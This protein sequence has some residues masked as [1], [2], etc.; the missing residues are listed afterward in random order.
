MASEHRAVALAA[1]RGAASGGPRR[2]AATL[3]HLKGLALDAKKGSTSNDRF[4]TE[5]GATC[6]S[7]MG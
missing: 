4:L 1:L 2:G 5:N 7:V 3:R 6:F